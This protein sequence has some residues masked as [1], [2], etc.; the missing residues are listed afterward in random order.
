MSGHP[1]FT[2]T[3]RWMPGFYTREPLADVRSK[4]EALHRA[5]EAARQ[6]PVGTDRW[7]CALHCPDGEVYYLGAEGRVLWVTGDGPTMTVAGR[8]VEVSVGRQ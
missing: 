2:L 7:R 8:A 5:Q 3:R 6:H 1:K 4:A